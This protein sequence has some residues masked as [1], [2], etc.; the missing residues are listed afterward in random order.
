VATTILAASSYILNNA[1]AF[2]SMVSL[3]GNG[4]SWD[5]I[6]PKNIEIKVGESVTWHNP[7]IVPE[8]HTVAFLGDPNYFPPPATPFS[9]SNIS[10]LI[11]VLPVPNMEPLIVANESGA[12]AVVIDNARHY[13]P[14]A[15]DSTG[16]NVTYLEI[17]ENYSM[18]GTEKFVNSGWIWPEGMAPPGL[19]PINSFTVTFGKPGTYDYLCVIHPWMN[20]VVTVT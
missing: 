13:T 11:S 17:N 12:N 2:D 19:P 8:P 6:T 4:S 14:V 18:T 9:I 3:G 7:M 5:A 15:I 1:N 16:N 20:G 10:E